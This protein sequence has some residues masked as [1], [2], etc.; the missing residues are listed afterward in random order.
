MRGPDCGAGEVSRA[1]AGLRLSWHQPY[2]LG[3][4]RKSDRR[5][6]ASPFRRQ[7]ENCPRPQ[8]RDRKL[9]GAQATAHSRRRHE[10]SFRYRYRSFGPPHRQHLSTAR[11]KRF[12]GAVGQRRA[13]SF[14]ASHWH[15]WNRSRSCRYSRLH[16]RCAPR[17]SARARRGQA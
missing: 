11:R 7:W 3:H 9:S 4:A 13:R 12:Q 17:Q 1:A 16:R 8:W 10:L 5:Q 2:P 14:K 15:I 6:C